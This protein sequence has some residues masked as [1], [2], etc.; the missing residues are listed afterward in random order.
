MKKILFVLAVAVVMTMAGGLMVP[1]SAAVFE[2]EGAGFTIEYDEEAWVLEDI[3]TMFGDMS[4]FDEMLISAPFVAINYDEDVAGV[5]VV[6]SERDD[7]EYDLLAFIDETMGGLETHDVF[8]A[9]DT[10]T[11]ASGDEFESKVR[12][13]GIAPEF[14][15]EGIFLSQIFFNE[16]KRYEV[17]FLA[18]PA[19]FISAWDSA[20]EI[21]DSID[22]E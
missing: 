22:V 12:A 1:A 16:G 19:N 17:C 18:L 7:Y 8:D 9:D 2:D 6:V 5:V 21:M 10:F 11:D 3:E 15:D 20:K 14:E 4:D 13:W